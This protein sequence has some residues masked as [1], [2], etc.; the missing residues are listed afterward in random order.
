MKNFIAKKYQKIRDN[1]FSTNEQINYDD[2]I[3][4]SIGDIDFTTDMEIIN[5]AF[6]DAKK[7]YT[8]YTESSGL[9]ELRDEICKYQKEEYGLDITNDEV[10]VST[11]AC[12]A[13]YLA[14]SCIIDEG[15]EVIIPTPHFSIYDFCIESKG[16]KVVYLPTYE[17]EDFGID[18]QRLEDLINPKTKALIINTPNNPTGTCLSKEN[19]EDIAKIVQKYDILV[20]ADDI[21]TLLSFQNPFIPIASVKN[22]KDRVITI[23]SFSKDFAM[24]GWRIGYIIASKEYIRVVKAINDN[25]IY[26]APSISQ[27]AALHALRSRKKI[28]EFIKKEFEDRLNLAYEKISRIPKL[29]V[30]PVKGTFYMFVNIKSTGMSCEEFCE[31]AKEKYHILMIPGTAF[32]EYGQGYVRLAMTLPKDKIQEAFDRIEKWLK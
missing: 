32:G 14:M 3:D 22:M 5:S 17:E 18:V 15:D 29:K 16:G 8:S 23:R 26:S 13:M 28:Q 24:T 19:L 10:F 11:S 4:F 30:L 1:A 31:E 7:G 27:R 9:V 21:Y 6:E 2:I 25:I 12:H 20:V